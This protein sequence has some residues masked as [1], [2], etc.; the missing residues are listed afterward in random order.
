M[1]CSI[2]LLGEGIMGRRKIEMA[3]VKD[4]SAKQVTFSFWA[5]KC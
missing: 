3:E 2:V 1:S 4:S 5:P